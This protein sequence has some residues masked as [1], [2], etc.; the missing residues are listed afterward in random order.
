VICV[1]VSM[2]KASSGSNQLGPLSV[3]DHLS[4]RVLVRVVSANDPP[5]GSAPPGREPLANPGDC[6][7]HD[8]AT[9]PGHRVRRERYPRSGGRHQTG[10][11]ADLQ[12]ARTAWTSAPSLRMSSTEVNR[13]A[14][15]VSELS[16][17]TLDERTASGTSPHPR[18]ALIRSAPARRR[19]SA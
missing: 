17:S 7:D 5:V 1:S 16:S 13:P 9:F 11:D 2:R 19:L 6:N 18:A 8:A 15:E 4:R 12:H 3:D 14:Y 10:S